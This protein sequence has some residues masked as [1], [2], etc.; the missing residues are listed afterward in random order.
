L[1]KNLITTQVVLLALLGLPLTA[2][3]I[4][5]AKPE[6]VGLSPERLQRV[7]QMIQRHIDAGDIS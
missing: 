4:P 2:A 7:H 1:N 6:D 5:T 3:S